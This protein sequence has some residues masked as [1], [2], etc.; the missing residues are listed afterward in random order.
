MALERDQILFWRFCRNPL[1]PVEVLLIESISLIHFILYHPG[2]VESVN[3]IHILFT[4][5]EDGI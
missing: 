1:E 5:P 3:E 2:N 4:V